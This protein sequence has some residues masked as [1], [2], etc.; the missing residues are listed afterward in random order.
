ML[1]VLD[2]LFASASASFGVWFLDLNYLLTYSFFHTN[3]WMPQ[4]LT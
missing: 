1:S 2:T 3:G 4:M